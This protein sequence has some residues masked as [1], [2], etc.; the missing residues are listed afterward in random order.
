MR[1]VEHHSAPGLFSD[2]HR[3]GG[4]RGGMETT[5]K[6]RQFEVTENSRITYCS[7]EHTHLPTARCTEYLQMNLVDNDFLVSVS[8]QALLK[9]QSWAG[10]A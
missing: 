10:I 9:F 6:M 3:H 2:P 7:T 8:K 5:G 1:K 4:Y